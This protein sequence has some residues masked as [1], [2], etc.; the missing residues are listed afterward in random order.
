M[1][2]G[3]SFGGGRG[4][5]ISWR[6]TYEMEVWVHLW[7]KSLWLK[8]WFGVMLPHET[9]PNQAHSHLCV[10]MSSS[11]LVLKNTL[12]DSSV[13]QI[14]VVTLHLQSWHAINPKILCNHP[15]HKVGAKIWQWVLLVLSPLPAPEQPTVH[16]ALFC[17]DNLH[18][19]S[20]KQEWPVTEF[21]SPL[22]HQYIV[23]VI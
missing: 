1:H 15:A 19:L 4:L 20:G 16:S 17:S 22:C 14:K 2:E 23:A 12:V 13:P 5:R 21:L 6:S 8:M 18:Q 3:K 11:L 10:F 9:V 7:E